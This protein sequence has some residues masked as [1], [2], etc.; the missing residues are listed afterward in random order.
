MVLEIGSHS[1]T[2][3]NT[4]TIADDGVVFTCAQDNNTSNKAYPRSTDP[5]SGSA[6]SITATTATTI[7]VNVGAVPVDEYVD[8]A[9]STEFG[10]GT[11]AY[12]IECWIKPNSIAAGS[13]AIFDMRTGATQVSAYLYLDS[14]NL[15]YY[16]N[17]SVVI[18]GA[19]NLAADTWYHV[20]VSRTSTTTKMFLNG[21]QE[22]SDFSDGGNYGSTKPV[23]IGAA[24]DASA[25]FPGY[26]DEFRISN[27]GRYTNTFTAPVGVFQGDA[28]TK[29]LLHFDGTYG[30]TWTEDW[31][32]V[33]AF[34]KGEEFNNGAILATSR[35]TGAPAGFAGKSQRYYD[36]ANLIESNKNFIAKEAVHALT[37]QYPSLVIPGGNVNCEDDIR[38][39]LGALIQDL[40]NGSNNH[41]WDASALYVDRTTNPISLNHVETEITETIWAY[42]KVDEILQ[43]IINNVLWTVAGSHGLTQATDTTITDASNPS[44]TTFNATGATY[45]AATG[46]LVITIGSHSLT[47]ASRIKLLTGGITFT[48]TKDG[49]D[50]PT[51]YPRATDPA[52]NAVLAV[53]AV[54]GT[55]ITVNVGA[56]GANDQYAHTYVSSLQNVVT[57]LDYSLTDCADVYTTINNLVDIL[58]DTL[59]Q[60]N[61]GT[62]VDHLATVTKVLPAIEFAGGTVNA[63]GDTTFDITYEDTANDIAYT[64]QI[65][66][67]AQY[68]FRDAANLIRA[69]RGVIVDKAAHDMLTRYPDLAQDMPRNDSGGSTDGTLRCKTDLGLIL[70]GLADDIENG[71]N[72]ETVTAAK[73]YIGGSGELL[74]IRLQVHQS[75]YAH[76]RLGYYAKQAITGDLTYDNTDNIIVGDWGITNDPGNCANVQTAIDTLVT[77]INDI[78]AP[79]GEDFNIAADRLYFNRQYLAE[80]ATGLTTA[81]F[82]YTLN[83]INYSA[84]TYPGSTGEATCQ[85]I[86]NSSFLQL[87]PTFK[88]VVMIAQSVLQKLI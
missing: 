79:T 86:S 20:A 17:G 10:F 1:L 22:G 61:A 38:D 28:N 11:D 35:V 72:L 83:G 49:N 24:F 87:F 59:T 34:T 12:T 77:T 88:Q 18:T 70:D 56:S 39:I 76:E 16:V 9:T 82:T 37:V 50:R 27:S 74:H 46:D 80:E 48:C 5:A 7:T 43:Y 55:T 32:G 19:T 66:L 85:E 13:K 65:D 75:V 44:Y 62:P 30:Q 42:N 53:T 52:A 68:R 64:N 21:T 67:D 26:I 54:S 69:N 57:V 60:A 31:S 47:T 63:F 15:K 40:R 8:I 71:G 73:F 23:R 36:A 78:I 81:E 58:T 45:D 25:D 3:S 2:T 6:L 33:E 29:L 84:F 14:A 4:V 51:A 41:I